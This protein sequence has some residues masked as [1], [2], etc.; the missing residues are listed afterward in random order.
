MRR[1]SYATRSD[2]VRRT[3][4][5]GAGSERR[6]S[7]SCISAPHG[8]RGVPPERSA[9]LFPQLTCPERPARVAAEN[10]ALEVGIRDRSTGS[11]AGRLAPGRAPGKAISAPAG[12]ALRSRARTAHQPA[13]PPALVDHEAA[14]IGTHDR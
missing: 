7:R 13:R 12:G 4:N 9:S 11:G 1:K 5:R 10:E 6:A 2:L 8:G 14:E 3:G